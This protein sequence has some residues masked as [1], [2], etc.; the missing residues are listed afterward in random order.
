MTKKTVESGE[1]SETVAIILSGGVVVVPVRRSARAQRARLS[2]SCRGE[3][4]FVAPRGVNAEIL[5][6]LAPRY[7][8]WLEKALGRV[9]K[10][11]ESAPRRIILAPAALILE[12]VFG[13]SFLEGRAFV[14][15]AAE[16]FVHDPGANRVLACRDG[17]LIRLFGS[18]EEDAVA[19]ALRGLLWLTG[20]RLAPGLVAEIG[21]ENGFPPVRVKVRDQRGR[22]GSFS[23]SSPNAPGIIN[24]N[25]RSLLL[26]VELFRH[27]CLH[28]YS[29]GAYMNHSPAFYAYLEKFNPAWREDEKALGEFWRN[30]PSW[31]VG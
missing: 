8:N 16:S 6:K 14:K 24:I 31:A 29:H 4:E 27:L 18:R 30:L 1:K 9:K 23:R 13:G 25:W 3:V 2:V 11:V 10:E 28:E 12:I 15:K 7:A 22:W 5:Q 26:P 20:K 17:D 21:A 19:R